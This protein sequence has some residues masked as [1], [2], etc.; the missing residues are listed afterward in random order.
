MVTDAHTHQWS[1]ANDKNLMENGFL[2]DLRDEFE[3]G[4]STNERQRKE[5]SRVPFSPRFFAF[6][7]AFWFAVW[8]PYISNDFL[9]KRNSW[10]EEMFLLFI[11]QWKKKLGHSKI[12]TNILNIKK[13]GRFSQH[14]K[15]NF[16]LD[17][18]L[19]KQLCCGEL[20]IKW[21]SY[22]SKHFFL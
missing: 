5:R 3:K 8:L 2:N 16:S 21:N 15:K 1:V 19:C 9:P 13:G 10:Q 14:K 20:W 22:S 17:F 4:F 7:F 11:R 18:A 12:W 6:A